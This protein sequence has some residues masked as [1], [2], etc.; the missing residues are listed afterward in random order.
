MVWSGDARKR[1]CRRGYVQERA[2]ILVQ[3]P[4][5]ALQLLRRELRE[6]RQV[7]LRGL[8]LHRVTCGDEECKEKDPLL[9]IYHSI[10]LIWKKR[11]VKKNVPKKVRFFSPKKKGGGFNTLSTVQN[12]LLSAFF[13]HDAR[14]QTQPPDW[15]WVSEATVPFALPCVPGPRIATHCAGRARR[16]AR[17]LADALP[18]HCT[19]G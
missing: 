5:L 17:S 16:T 12:A 14:R 7:A 18:A 3:M 1:T 2:V 9:I 13:C 6:V 8:F 15:L 19:R 10:R 4:Q 11:K